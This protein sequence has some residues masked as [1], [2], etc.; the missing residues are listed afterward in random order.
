MTSLTHVARLALALLLLSGCSEPPAREPDRRQPDG[1]RDGVALPEAV[2]HDPAEGIVEVHLEAKVAKLELRP[3]V[4]T[5]VWT[6]DGRLPGTLIRAKRGQRLV[7]KFTNNLPEPTTIHWHGVRVPASMDGSELVQSP[8][9]PGASF[10]YAFDLLDSGTYWYHPHVRSSPQVGSG[11]YGA[12]II[13]EAE[14]PFFGDEATLILSDIGLEEDGTLTP[15]DSNGWFGDYFGR[16]GNVLLVN[17]RVHPTLKLREGVSQRWRVINAARSRYFKFQV[18][19]Q[20][21]V[22]IASGGGVA[23]HT[24]EPEFV[25]LAP[26][27]RA[28]VIVTIEGQRGGTVEIQG[29]DAN[30]FRLPKP[31]DPV[32]LFALEIVDEAAGD[33]VE[34]PQALRTIEPLDVSSS[35]LRRFEF[36][37]LEGMQGDVLTIHVD[38]VPSDH[39]MPVHVQVGSTEIWELSNATPYDHPFHLHGFSFQVLDLDGHAPQVREWKDTINV[40]PNQ[41]IRVGVHFDDRPG[42]WMYHCHILDHADLGMMG[43]LMVMP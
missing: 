33:P 42:H 27:E 3:G 23:E 20:R 41:R 25:T 21:W 34:L 15:L 37:E 32:P 16:E 4:M 7:V 12:L 11:L 29:H 1:W 9:Q 31:A 2:D 14:E 22:R 18:P 13:E 39:S 40:Q 17:G 36:A 8:V 28:E 43:A 19:G 10:T 38:G 30:R 26:G 5:E 35:R 24:L 6:Y